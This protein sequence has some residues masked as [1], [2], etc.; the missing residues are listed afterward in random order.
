MMALILGDGANPVG[1]GQRIG[2]AR[3]VE[4]PLEPGDAV[5]F[6]KVPVGDLALEV[7]DLGLGHPR[8]VAAAG[9]AAFARQCLHR[10]NLP[11]PAALGRGRHPQPGS[12]TAP[13]AS[14]CSEN[15]M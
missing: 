6:Y 9:D 7:T 10:V 8:R 13:A 12:S 4:D 2:E 3:E 15:N 14:Y 1:E 5:A 11:A